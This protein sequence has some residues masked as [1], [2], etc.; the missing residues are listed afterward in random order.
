MRFFALT[1]VTAAL[2]STFPAC[3][4]K[5]ADR[6]L[7]GRYH[8]VHPEGCVSD[9][10]D[11][12]L[13]IREDGTYDQTVQLKNGR[14]ETVENRHWAYDRTQRRMTFSKFLVSGET[15][16]A[17]EAS[18]PAL[19]NRPLFCLILSILRVC[20]SGQP[21]PSFKGYGCIGMTH[22]LTKAPQPPLS[23]PGAVPDSERAK[24]PRLDTPAPGEEVVPGDRVEGLGNF[25]KPTGEIGTVEQTNEDDAIVKWDD[26]GR[27]RLRQPWL[28]KL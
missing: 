18:H 7:I 10:Q 6:P 24:K 13:V 25:G 17:A 23:Y 26:D 28:K 22:K 9:I 5:S 12:T 15:S 2:L 3:I 27:M 1:F 11:S 8:L 16:F 21:N 14:N 20:S 19:T 4:G